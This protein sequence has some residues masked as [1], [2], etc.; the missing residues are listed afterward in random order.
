M[1]KFNWNDFAGGMGE[2]LPVGVKVVSDARA[3]YNEGERRDLDQMFKFGQ[4][5]GYRM[6]TPGL[7]GLVNPTGNGAGGGNRIT[8]EVPTPNL[9]DLSPRALGGYPAGDVQ[10]ALDYEGGGTPAG[11]P[12]GYGPGT[13][14]P[15]EFG[16][17]S[18]RAGMPPLAMD[19]ATEEWYAGLDAKRRNAYKAGLDNAVASQHAKDVEHWFT[20]YDQMWG[21]FTAN[22]RGIEALE[23]KQAKMEAELNGAQSLKDAVN[24]A[25]AGG[26]V[27]LAQMAS[28]LR[29]MGVMV[30]PNATADQMHTALEVYAN[31]IRK[32]MMQDSQQYNNLLDAAQTFGPEI[33]RYERVLQ[34]LG[35]PKELLDDYANQWRNEG[36]GGGGLAREIMRAG[37]RSMPGYTGRFKSGDVTTPRTRPGT[38][39][40]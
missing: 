10:F 25:A 29:K 5:G 31:T 1:P 38:P 34:G 16:A 8:P 27:P 20:S 40:R 11:A 26:S 18:P 15:G 17:P 32:D 6:P 4:L 35:V 33:K 24:Q 36:L 39:P 13:L 3:L 2:A 23:A 22:R 9:T 19:P 12:G 21:K 28:N 37:S 14:T 30:A 7:G